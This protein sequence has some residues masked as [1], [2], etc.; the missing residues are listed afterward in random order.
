[1]LFLKFG[2][3]SQWHSRTTFTTIKREYVD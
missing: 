1:M 2:N 3:M